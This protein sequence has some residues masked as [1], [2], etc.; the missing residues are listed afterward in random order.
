MEKIILFGL[1]ENEMDMIR[2]CGL[3]YDYFPF[4]VWQD[5]VAHYAELSIINPR[6]LEDSEKK[7]LAEFYH[8]IDP[9][10]EKVILT[11]ED[12][13]FRGISFI[14]VIPDLFDF[15]ESIHIVLMKALKETKRD[16]DFSVRIMLAIKIMKLIENNPGITTKQISERIECSDRSTKRYIN[17]LRSAGLM[18]E[19]QNRGWSFIMDPLEL[20]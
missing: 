1:S 7:A 12:P 19:Y 20:I 3:R 5:V 4:E 6:T 14:E 15:P 8:D 9:C 2:N 11:N 17:S 18:I 16:V 10:D 13:N